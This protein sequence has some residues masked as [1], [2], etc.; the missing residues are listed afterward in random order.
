M[1]RTLLLALFLAH[2]TAPGSASTPAAPATDKPPAPVS[3]AARVPGGVASL[4]D[5]VFYDAPGDG[6][7]WARGASY[8]AGFSAAG[9]SFVPWLGARA[10]ENRP[11]ALRPAALTSDGVALGFDASAAPRRDGDVVAFDRASFVESYRIGLDS[12]EQVFV[13]ASL[14]SRGEL[15]LSIAADSALAPRAEADHMRFESDLG[16]VRYGRALALDAGGRS[17]PLATTHADGAIEIR[18]PAAFLATAALPLTIDP[19]I[20]TFAVDATTFDDFAPDVAYD[21]ANDRYMVCYEEAFSASDHDVFERLLDANGAL[22]S[23]Q[24]VDV[25]GTDWRR[26]RIANNAGAA[27]FLVTAHAGTTGS[28]SIVGRV[29]SAATN[30]LGNQTV[31]APAFFDAERVNADVGGDPGTAGTTYYLVV[32]EELQL[33]TG[34][35]AIVQDIVRT[36]GVP[37]IGGPVCVDCNPGKRFNPAVSKS[38]GPTGSGLDST[39]NIVWEFQ[40][41][42][43]DHDI[44]GAQNYNALTFA[45]PFPIDTSFAN[46]ARPSVSS[47][48][49]ETDAPGRYLVAYE[50]QQGPG[51]RDLFGQVLAGATV[52]AT[53]NLSALEGPSFS[54]Q[55]QIRPDVDSDG[56]AFAVVY[57]ELYSTSTV[58]YD[59]YVSTFSLAA[60]D[61]IVALESHE[62]LAFTSEPD[63]D[64]QITAT[65]GGPEARYAQAWARLVPGNGEIDAGLYASETVAAFCFPGSGAVTTSCPCNNPPAAFGLGCDN[66]LGTGGA[67]LTG[68][69]SPSLSADTFEL[70]QTG[71]LPTSLSIFLQGSSN[72]AAGATFGGGVRCAGGALKRLYVHNAVGGGVQAPVGADPSVSAASAALG[73]VIPPGGTRFYQVYYRDPDVVFCSGG[74]NVGNGLQVLWVP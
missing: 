41:T 55:D 31:V 28:R 4:H 17:T 15:V 48:L 60:G 38:A 39:W 9:T 59:V 49:D 3:R 66:S 50:R 68:P 25:T 42:V 52:R 47:F 33:S 45:G 12:I 61:E 35:R 13:F 23:G 44:Y 53:A 34:R 1:N 65:H 63:L 6:S 72:V 36:D 64:A 19:V 11:L 62:N 30:A 40:Y 57:S 29:A 8:K 46:E 51:S 71:E 37:A 27:N 5:R 43:G 18:V 54:A 70:A 22:V 32:F 20:T 2:A 14:P 21:A 73:D 26:P 58:D 56:R 74:F 7:I 10:G 16:G 69:G 67:L 24:Y